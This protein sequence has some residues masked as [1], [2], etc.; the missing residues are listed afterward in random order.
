MTL[1]D[2][3]KLRFKEVFVPN[4]KPREAVEVFLFLRGMRDQFP[5]YP[6]GDITIDGMS[7]EAWMSPKE[8]FEHYCPPTMI[9]IVR[10]PR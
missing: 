1:R 9:C 4:C 10:I 5:A 7:E 6:D 3:H 8:Y 2:A